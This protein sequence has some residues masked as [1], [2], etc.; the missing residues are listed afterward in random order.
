[1]KNLD[2]DC[3]NEVN[4]YFNKNQAPSRG[5]LGTPQIIYSS[6]THAQLSQA[7]QE[8]KRSDYSHLKASV[9]GSREQMCIHPEII[10]EESNSVKINMCRMKVKSHS[11]HFYNRV[12]RQKVNP[13]VTEPSIVDI[14]DIVK[15]GSQHKFCPYY[16]SKELQQKANII[17]MPYNYL[18][19]ARVRKSI[20]VELTNN[21][22]I[23]DEAHNIER[24]CEDSA[25]LQIK[26]TDI[27][28]SI[29]GVT[30][31]MKVLSSEAGD[32]GMSYNDTPPD[33]SPD[34]LCILKQIFL[35][36][37]QVLDNIEI[38]NHSE[39]ATF[40]GKYIF[41]MMADSGV[42]NENCGTV[43]N[44]V[45]KLNQFMT[46]AGEGVFQKWTHGLSLFE[47]LLRIVFIN[48]EPNYK[49]KLERCYKVH[50]M[51]EEGEKQKQ[52]SNWLSKASNKVKPACRVLSFWCF[53]P[54][55][56]MNI[57]MGQ[58]V[59]S[60]ILTSGTLAPLPPL[61]TELE[62]NVGFQLENPHIVKGDQICVKILSKGPDGQILN[63]N[64]QNRDNPKYIT[65]LGRTVS[66][67]IRV[68][69][70]GML[71]FFPSYV[72]LRKCKDSWQES[73]L[74]ASMNERKN[75]F[76][77]PKEK[78][79]FQEAM[80]NFYKSV[81]DPNLQGAIFMGVCRGKVSEGLDFADANG[82][83]VLITGL[84]FPPLKD[85]RIVLKKQYLDNC[86]L[87]NREYL[88]GNEWYNLEAAK[89]VNQAIGRVIRHRHDYGAIILLDTR[90]NNSNVLNHMSMWLRKYAKNVSYVDL[91]K[92]LK[93]FFEGAAVKFPIGAVKPPIKKECNPVIGCKS[94]N[95][96][97][98]P[99][100]KKNTGPNFFGNSTAKC[101]NSC[102]SSSEIEE[103]TFQVK[104]RKI[105]L[106]PNK[107]IQDD[108]E[109]KSI[110]KQ[111]VKDYLIMVKK[112]LN[113]KEYDSFVSAIKKYRGDSEIQS[114]F[115]TLDSIFMSRS[116][117][118]HL[119]L[120]LRAYI[121][122]QHKQSLEEYI[123]KWK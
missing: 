31:A 88:N 24:I 73:G 85:P 96:N 72:M 12:E 120:G 53:S 106:I 113:V 92:D 20:G 16:M 122:E 38:K 41:K 55:F 59:K 74:W 13:Q 33:F 103:S 107:P 81:H 61:I 75:I 44:L 109:N 2:E 1:M 71:V 66:N 78:N 52:S 26:S 22:V 45:D 68:I 121:R 62:L 64:Y 17:F 15:L 3:L 9:I 67:L 4:Q 82:R 80:Q 25:S 111:D 30:E 118:W 123:L 19:D 65:S 46:T 40:E 86:K 58:G 112:N 50:V 94:A 34:E 57:L 101:S 100:Y 99:S 28:L 54:G 95:F 6:R 21:I 35:D 23:L 37:E 49:Q 91:M 79:A 102:S 115:Q 76:V 116:S 98:V 11:C 29:E 60:V 70:H 7:M 56:G 43:I 93:V 14:E 47:D 104:R 87:K 48:V 8:L 27:V 10:K 69:P 89:A 77:E 36:F 63:C 5:V 42:T 39:G 32:M 51:M 105:T 84:P 108:T 110:T 83:A 97:I 18:L 117:S 90:F 119:M 114:L